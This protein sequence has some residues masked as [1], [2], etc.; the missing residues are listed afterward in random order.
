MSYAE[1]TSKNIKNPSVSVR[2][3]LDLQVGI[4]YNLIPDR[5]HFILLRSLFAEYHLSSRST[6]RPYG[7]ELYSTEQVE[8]DLKL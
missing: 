2:W 7:I 5:V 6:D 4:C 1:L 8:R 3:C